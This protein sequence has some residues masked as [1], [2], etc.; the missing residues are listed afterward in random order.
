MKRLSVTSVIVLGLC[1][2][3]TLTACAK[4]KDSDEDKVGDTAFSAYDGS[5]SWPSG[6]SSDVNKD[7]SVP[8]YIG[9]PDKSFKVIGRIYDERQG[10]LDEVG[11]AFSEGLGSEKHRMRDVA[12]QAKHHGANAVIVTDDSDVI[13]AFSLSHKEVHESAPLFKYKHSVVLAVKM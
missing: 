6:K 10:G 12:N 9:L 1:V 8:I 5:Q 13:K 11:K 2:A 7:Y 3:W 4:D